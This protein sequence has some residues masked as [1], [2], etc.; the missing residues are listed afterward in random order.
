MRCSTGAAR[1]TKSCCSGPKAR[2]RSLSEELRLEGETERRAAGWSARYYADDDLQDNNRTLLGQNAN[3]A[4]IRFNGNL[5]LATPFNS[6][7][8]TAQQMAQAFRTYRD[9]GD[10]EIDDRPASSPTRTGR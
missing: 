9:L 7:G 10:M 2:S 8:Y 5:L 3:V 6:G 1:L 4:A